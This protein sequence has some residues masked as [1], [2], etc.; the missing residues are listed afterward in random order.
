M[1]IKLYSAQWCSQC[2]SVKD[3]LM[4]KGIEYEVVDVDET[5]EEMDALVAKGIRGLPV[6]G[7]DGDLYVGMR[8][9][10]EFVG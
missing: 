8:G 5:P 7:A 9:A 2:N 1:P 6:I 10:L 3:M 4:Q